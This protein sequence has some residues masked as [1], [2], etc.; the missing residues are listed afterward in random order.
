MGPLVLYPPVLPFGYTLHHRFQRVW[1]AGVY[2]RRHYPDTVIM[3]AGLL[4]KLQGQVLSEFA[5]DYDAVAIY[6]EPQMLPVVADLAERL[7]HMSSLSKI[8]VYGPATVCFPHRVQALDVDA[9]AHGGDVEA[10]LR[11]FADIVTGRSDVAANLKLRI[12][13]GWARPIGHPETVPADEWAFPPIGEMPMTD[14]A[15]IYDMKGQH[16]TVAVTAARG[17]PYRCAF[18]ATPSIE[19][20]P[21]RRRPIPALVDFMRRYSD[22]YRHWQMYAPTFTLDRRWCLDFFAA[23]RASQ[24]QVNWRCT[25]RVDR[26]DVELVEAMAAAGCSMVGIGVETLGPTLDRID[27]EI[28]RQQVASALSMLRTAGIRAKAYIML[29]LPGQSIA[30]VYET[31]RFVTDL[32]AEIRPTLYSPQGEADALTADDVESD[33]DMLGAMDRKSFLVGREHYGELLRLTFDR[34]IAS[35]Q[36]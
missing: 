1:E 25:T 6:A 16:V 35:P 8:L 11:Q 21:D 27:K 4:N 5:R 2:L 7:R 15:R 23:L 12:A 19:G 31:I 3:D 10:Q 34:R 33:M 14:I 30:E 32:G 36:M 17:C 18:C 9:I 13:G 24:V 29:G 28:S 26:L 20:R 22:R